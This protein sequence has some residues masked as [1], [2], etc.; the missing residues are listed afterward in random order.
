MRKIIVSENI[1]LDGVME[2]P[3][4]NEQYEHGGWSNRYYDEELQKLAAENM[5]K[6]N[7]LLLGRVTYQMFAS[8]FSAQSGGFA[9]AMN[10]FPKYVVSTT[11]KQADWNNSTLIQGNVVDELIRLKQEDGADIA[12][13]GSGTL[14]QTLMAHDLVDE[15]SILVFPVVLGSG[16]RLFGDVSK[17]SLKLIEAKPLHSGIVMLSYQPA[18]ASN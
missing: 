15:Y 18:A 3:T 9:D 7:P 14:V 17:T 13:I 2:D 12:V 1:S 10:A 8:V 11:L 16:K 4:G 5:S 6:G